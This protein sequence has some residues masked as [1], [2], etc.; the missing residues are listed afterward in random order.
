MCTPKFAH[1]KHNTPGK[2]KTVTKALCKHAGMAGEK[3]N[4]DAK[5]STKFHKMPRICLA[6]KSVQAY[7]VWVAAHYISHKHTGR[8]NQLQS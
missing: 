4:N 6:K 1:F 3:P 2:N 5:I 8:C 7:I